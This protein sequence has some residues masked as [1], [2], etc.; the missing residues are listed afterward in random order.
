MPDSQ[1]NKG[2]KEASK[3]TTTM[4]EVQEAKVLGRDGTSWRIPIAMAGRRYGGGG[5]AKPSLWLALPETRK[6][7]GGARD[8]APAALAAWMRKFR[9]AY[10]EHVDGFHGRAF[11]A[12]VRRQRQANMDWKLIQ[13][14]KWSGMI[15]AAQDQDQATSAA[16]PTAS[17][18]P[19][20]QQSA[21]QAGAPF[22]N[23]KMQP[24]MHDAMSQVTD[25][26]CDPVVSFVLQ[27]SKRSLGGDDDFC[28]FVCVLA[29]VCMPLCLCLCLCVCVLACVCMPLCLCVCVSVSVSVS[30][31]VCVCVCV[32][33]SLPLCFSASLP[34]C[35]SASLHTRTCCLRL[36]GFVS[37]ADSMFG[38]GLSFALAA[39][40]RAGSAAAGIHWRSSSRKGHAA[41]SEEHEGKARCGDE[42]A[43]RE[44][45][46]KS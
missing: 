37:L 44:Q 18:A 42:A 25:K 14:A 34:L 45:S 31:C 20:K 32:S 5:L 43:E 10:E 19:K 33:V 35:L 41:C 15:P 7:V 9:E 28:A 4:E 2:R 26:V 24:L 8:V 40:A 23:K 12:S 29:C 3:P 46:N 30:V 36:V 17:K 22:T 11:A 27:A 39:F 38:P 6:V 13:H 21:Q 1:T 16:A